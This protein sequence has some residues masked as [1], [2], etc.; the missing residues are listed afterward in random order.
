MTKAPQPTPAVRIEI[1]PSPFVLSITSAALG[2]AVSKGTHYIGF[3]PP[4]DHTRIQVS[5]VRSGE[6]HE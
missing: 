2:L 1:Q 3:T 4:L 5:H 6:E